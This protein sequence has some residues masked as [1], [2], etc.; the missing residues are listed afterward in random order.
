VCVLA[1]A[2]LVEDAARL[3]LAVRVNDRALASGQQSQRVRGDRRVVRQHLQSRDQRVAPEECHEPWDAGREIL[4][5]AVRRDEHPQVGE[6][7]L[8]DPL[9]DRGAGPDPDLVLEPWVRWGRPVAVRA[10]AALR[11]H[12][13]RRRVVHFEDAARVGQQL[14]AVLGEA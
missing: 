6:R 8:D 13:G 9:E 3:L 4:L 5:A 2:Q 14:V 11:H 7:A 1:D 12:P 10:P